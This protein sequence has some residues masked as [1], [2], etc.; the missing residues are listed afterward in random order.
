MT[1]LLITGAN[2]FVGRHLLAHIRQRGEADMEVLATSRTAADDPI[3]GRFAAL[4]IADGEATAAALRDFRPTHV[5][6]LAG[7]SSPVSAGGDPMEIWRTNMDATVR[8]AHAILAHAPQCWLLF[9]GSGLVY[10]ATARTRERLDEDCLLAPTN[11]YAATKA[12]ADLALGALAGSGLKT[13]RLRPFNHTGPGQTDAFVVPAFAAQIARIEAGREAPVMR[14][15][16]LSAER[17]FL[18]VRDVVDA[19]LACIAATTQ[20]PSGTILNIA[21][22][23][24]RRM[25]D[26][27]DQLLAMS[28]VRIHVETDPARLR[29]G[30]IARYVGD[31][32]RAERLI[33]WRPQRRFED[34]LREVLETLRAGV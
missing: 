26:V 13:L 28:C 24:P 10:G 19:Y 7:I 21:S 17:D 27:L 6:H 31:A 34:T 30:D 16:D 20:L 4:D 23:V 2:G 3:L 5:M 8:L 1:R 29:P 9:A 33:G 15:G 32:A 12:A 11:A 25:R 18:D 14:V 22:G